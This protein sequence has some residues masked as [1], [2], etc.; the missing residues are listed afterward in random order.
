MLSPATSFL[1]V[2]DSGNN[3]RKRMLLWKCCWLSVSALAGAMSFGWHPETTK[4][5]TH[6][7]PMSSIRNTILRL[8]QQVSIRGKATDRQTDRDRQTETDRD[9]QRQTET[10]RDRQRQTETDRDRQTETETE[11]KTETETETETETDRHTHT[12]MRGSWSL[13][14]C[15][16]GKGQFFWPNGAPLFKAGAARV[17][18]VLSRS[19]QT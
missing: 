18:S 17:P 3:S 9:R 8:P 16:Q 12:H 1:N 5:V 2:S 15:S 11:T 7:V 13:P 14:P 19:S 6:R 10:D 4:R